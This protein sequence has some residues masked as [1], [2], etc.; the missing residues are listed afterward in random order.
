MRIGIAA[1]TLYHV[2]LKQGSIIR[3]H[4]SDMSR[5]SCLGAF[6]CCQGQKK[7]LK[8]N[9]KI[10]HREDCVIKIKMGTILCLLCGMAISTSVFAQHTY[11]KVVVFGDSLSDPGNAFAL[12]GNISMRPFSL[13]PDAPYARGGMHFSNGKTWVE[14]L[15]K[16]LRLPS[17]PAFRN[18]GQFSNYAV[19]SARARSVTGADLTDQV[20]MF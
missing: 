10:K 20:N 3:H 11:T 17:G 16:D 5:P 1:L 19:G 9:L 2:V 7:L 8:N 15:S 18:P 6:R 4:D 14:V 12:T 13:I